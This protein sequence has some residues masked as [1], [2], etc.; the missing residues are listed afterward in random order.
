[1]EAKTL[2]YEAKNLFFFLSMDEKCCTLAGNS[3]FVS[4]VIVVKLIKLSYCHQFKIYFK[5]QECLQL[6]IGKFK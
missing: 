3:V 2:F 1:M 5:V 4:S 6:F